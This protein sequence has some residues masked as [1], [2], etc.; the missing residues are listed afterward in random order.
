MRLRPRRSRTPALAGGA[1]ERRWKAEYMKMLLRK[2]AAVAGPPAT[3]HYSGML[4]CFLAG[5]ASRLLL[6]I[7][8]ALI[9]RGRVRR[10]SMTSSR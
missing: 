1:R 5:L 6:S 10:G 3:G 8:R 7:S 2:G 4:P 9:R